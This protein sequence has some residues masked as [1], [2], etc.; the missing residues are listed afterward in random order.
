MN[1]E[2]R[3]A[4]TFA[5]VS[6]SDETPQHVGAMV[7]VGRSVERFS[8]EEVTVSAFSGRRRCGVRAISVLPV[9]AISRKDGHLLATKWD[10]AQAIVGRSLS[11]SF[12]TR[13]RRIDTIHMIQGR[14]VV[15]SVCKRRLS[16]VYL[17]M[18]WANLAHRFAT[19]VDTAICRW[20]GFLGASVSMRWMNERL[21]ERRKKLE[22]IYKRIWYK[23]EL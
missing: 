14:S 3:N 16:S 5:D 9:S 1:E 22:R 7:A 18:I 10:A 4:T 20:I 19:E 8:T 13:N 21:N 23:G 2:N 6:L 15:R 17:D 11:E 12:Y